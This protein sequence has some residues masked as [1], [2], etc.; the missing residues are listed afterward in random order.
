MKYSV[1]SKVFHRSHGLGIVSSIESRTLYNSQGESIANE[2]YV[3][4]I[5]D[6]G[7]PKKVFVPLET[8]NQSLRPCVDR[9]QAERLIKILRERTVVFTFESQTWNRRYREYMECIH[10]GDALEIARVANALLHLR[11]E[12]ELSFGERKLLDQALNLI[13]LEVEN[14]GLQMP[15]V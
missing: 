14:A 12:K 10:S 9:V 5:A 13:R 2:F 7:A 15:E 1:G 8:A 4:H 6:N 11:R 3:L